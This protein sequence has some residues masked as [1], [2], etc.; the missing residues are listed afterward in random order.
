[1]PNDEWVVKLLNQLPQTVIQIALERLSGFE[2]VPEFK[3]RQIYSKLFKS[4]QANLHHAFADK[5][6]LAYQTL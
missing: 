6:K 3:K 2:S 5:V 4:I 1:M